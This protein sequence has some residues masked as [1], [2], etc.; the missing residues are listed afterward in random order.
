M[1]NLLHVPNSPIVEEVVELK[2]LAEATL[3]SET[4]EFIPVLENL[5][6]PSDEQ[7]LKKWGPDFVENKTISYLTQVISSTVP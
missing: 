2:F 1:V 6:L 7:Q 3:I 4:T 5:I